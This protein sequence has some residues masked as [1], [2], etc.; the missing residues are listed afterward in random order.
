MRLRVIERCLLA[1]LVVCLPGAARA[2]E[3]EEASS[4]VGPTSSGDILLGFLG[5]APFLAKEGS[6]YQL[7]LGFGFAASQKTDAF[8]KLP[9]ASKDV[10]FGGFALSP[11]F[12]GVG[13]P[14]GYQVNVSLGFGTSADDSGFDYKRSFQLEVMYH[15]GA[16]LLG[17]FGGDGTDALTLGPIL[18]VQIGPKITATARDGRGDVSFSRGAVVQLGPAL[19]YESIGPK[20]AFGLMAGWIP[21]GRTAN[22]VTFYAG[23]ATGAFDPAV[24]KPQTYGDAYAAL[25]SYR[26]DGAVLGSVYL[27]K[28]LSGSSK[29]PGLTLGLRGDFRRTPIRAKS[30]QVGAIRDAVESEIRVFAGL[31]ISFPQ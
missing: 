2:A 15:A 19:G 5:V 1:V 28:N 6:S 26:A 3:N 25:E 9:G 27:N 12:L 18:N 31:G 24:A 20:G 8:R 21:P 22:M 16:N 10:A 30:E 14:V 29:E 23:D 11:A 17:I 7:G 13:R 4:K